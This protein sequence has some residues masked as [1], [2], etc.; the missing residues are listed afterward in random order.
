MDNSQCER[1]CPQPVHAYEEASI[2]ASA[3]FAPDATGC[4]EAMIPQAES[5]SLAVTVATGHAGRQ[6]FGQNVQARVASARD[7]RTGSLEAMGQR[8]S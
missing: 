3:L 8:G 5:A 4:K 7:A 1:Q 6:S 2:S